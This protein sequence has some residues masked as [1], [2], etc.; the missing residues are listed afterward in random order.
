MFLYA[1]TPVYDGRPSPAPGREKLSPRGSP[2]DA[3]LLRLCAWGYDA[4]SDIFIKNN[5]LDIYSSVASVL[6]PWEDDIHRRCVML[7]VL[8]VLAGAESSWK[9]TDGRD[10]TNDNV[11][12]SLNEETGIFQVSADSMGFGPELRA[13]VKTRLGSDSARTFIRGMKF[14]YWLAMEYC[15]RLLR[16]T[17]NHNGPVKFKEIHP[18][19]SRDAVAEFRE[20]LSKF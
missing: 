6:G 2:P 5:L 20:I 1:K 13:L 12:T 7:E 3:F 10:N 8:R 14:D 15:A 17:V 11:D 9:W 16:R 19:L 18:F 4:P